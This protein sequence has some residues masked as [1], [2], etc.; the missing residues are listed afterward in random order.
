MK[1]AAL[2]AALLGILALSVYGVAEAWKGVGL[3]LSLHGWIAL[4]LGVVVSIGLGVGLMSLV[5]Y[6]A[7]RGYDDHQDPRRE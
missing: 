5:F 2:V 7:R 1:L 3:E 4:S 6:S